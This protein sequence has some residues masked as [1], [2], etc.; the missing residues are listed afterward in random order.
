MEDQNYG[1]FRVGQMCN[2]DLKELMQRVVEQKAS[3]TITFEPDRT[4][5]SVTPWRPYT[6]SCPYKE[7]T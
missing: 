7:G 5:I 1:V 3:V 4:E 6:P 2:I